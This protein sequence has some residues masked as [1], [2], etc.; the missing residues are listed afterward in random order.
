MQSPFKIVFF[1]I[2]WTLYDHKNHCWPESALSSIKKLQAE[3]IKVVLCTARPFHSLDRFGV[4]DLGIAWDGYVSSAGGVAYAD[5][6]YLRKLLMKDADVASFI[7][8][9]HERHLTL[10]IV[11]PLDRIL[12]FPQTYSSRKFYRAYHESIPSLG[13]YS[14]QEVVAF[15]FF[16]PKSRDKEMTSLFPQLIYSRYFD[17]AVDVMPAP[18]LKGEA[19]DDILRHY[20]F[21]KE[22]SLG[23]GDDLQDISIAE[24]VGSFVCMGNGKDE[25]KKVATYVTSEVWSDGVLQG[26]KHFGLVE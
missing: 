7:K 4:N 23:F 21:K 15:N 11:G 2:D 13:S 5:H 16:A 14:G 22:E 18:H 1:D 9:A 17:Y 24:H 25:V 20:G 6:Q 19:C 10:E 26:L 3:G 8:A 12:L